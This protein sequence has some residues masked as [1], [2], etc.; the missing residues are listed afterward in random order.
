MAFFPR[1][2]RSVFRIV[3]NRPEL[4][5]ERLIHAQFRESGLLSLGESGEP[6]EP[7]AMIRTLAVRA[8]GCVSRGHGRRDANRLSVFCIQILLFPRLLPTFRGKRAVFRPILGASHSEMALCALDAKPFTAIEASH[9]SDQCPT[10]PASA[11]YRVVL[12]R[13][14]E[15]LRQTSLF[16]RTFGS[17]EVIEK[18][19]H[20]PTARGAGLE[21][22]EERLAQ[23][24]PRLP[25]KSRRELPSHIRH[26]R[27]HRRS[28]RRLRPHP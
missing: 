24:R 18:R 2:R 17:L 12:S 16:V 3:A 14:F 9:R 22:F 5:F 19:R 1:F 23:L 25:P 10:F 13:A 28:R 4:F 15:L 11:R 6:L 7:S 8:V 20:P 21:R 26:L 27:Y